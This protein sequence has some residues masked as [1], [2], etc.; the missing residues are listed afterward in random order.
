MMERSTKR[1]LFQS[2]GLLWLRLRREWR[3]PYTWSSGDGSAFDSSGGGFLQLV[4]GLSRRL[5]D[6]FNMF[7]GGPWAGLG[8]DDGLFS[9]FGSAGLAP[10]QKDQDRRRGVLE[11]SI[12]IGVVEA[13]GAR[14][15]R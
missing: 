6:F 1:R 11:D 14:P 2:F 15:E 5:L 9:G 12:K 8:A 3:I 4:Q 10:G 7:F 13:Y